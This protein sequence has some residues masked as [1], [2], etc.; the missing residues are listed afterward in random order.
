MTIDLTQE[1]YS[2]SDISQIDREVRKLVT[3]YSVAKMQTG[4]ELAP[5]LKA[6]RDHKLYL[7][8]DEDSYPTFETYIKSLGD[9]SYK[10]ALNFI[11][12]YEAYVLTAKMSLDDLK[13]AGYS[14]LAIIKPHLFDFDKDAGGYKLAKPKSEIQKWVKEASSEITEEDLRQHRR[15]EKAG[16]HKH[17][18]EIIKLRICKV[19]KLKERVY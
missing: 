8:L 9:Y 4:L 15:E 17:D 2:I 6:I 5:R 14:K 7:K 10:T 12:I 16:E 11:A 19:C 13:E 1:K 18:F 3:H